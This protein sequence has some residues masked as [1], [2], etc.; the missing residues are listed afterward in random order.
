MYLCFDTSLT[1][2]PSNSSLVG[3][4][5]TT[6][7]I[8]ASCQAGAWWLKLD[9]VEE[10]SHIVVVEEINHRRDL[11]SSTKDVEMHDQRESW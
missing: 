7:Y 4:C 5:E 1:F 3:K 2:P 11:K 6:G 10:S 8:K 9:V